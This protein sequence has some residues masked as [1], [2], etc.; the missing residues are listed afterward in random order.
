MTRFRTSAQEW[1]QLL[2]GPHKVYNTLY[3]IKCVLHK[4]NSK[5]LSSN[6]VE[7]NGLFV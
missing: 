6:F 2:A 5:F 3:D 7:G 1:V 4:I